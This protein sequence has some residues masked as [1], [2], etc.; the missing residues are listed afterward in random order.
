MNDT[1]KMAPIAKKNIQKPP[2]EYLFDWRGIDAYGKQIDGDIRAP[3]QAFAKAQLARQGIRTKRVQK[4]KVE[5]HNSRIKPKDISVF[6]RQLATMMKAGLPLLQAFDIVARGS[7]NPALSLLIRNIRS[8]V[9]TGTAMSAA[10]RKFPEYFSSLYCNLI[11]AG[12]AAGILDAMLDRLAVYLEKTEALKSKIKSALMY[13]SAVVLISITVLTIIMVFVVPSFKKIFASFGQELPAPTLVVIALS[14]AFVDNWYFI[15]G[16]ILIGGFVFLRL[17][18]TDTALQIW[19]DRSKLR[20]PIVGPLIEKACV[21]RW[22]RTLSTM[23]AAGV[24]LVEA[25]TSVGAAAGNLVFER[26]T[27]RIRQE[28]SIGTSLGAA[29]TRSKLFPELVLQMASIGEESGALDRMLAK[30][31]DFYEAEID[32]AVAGLS[33]LI[34]P[35]IIVVLGGVIGSIVVAMYLP[36]F[37]MGNVV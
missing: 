11:A 26:G 31:A 8:D 30:V 15:L 14:D 21:A 2:K 1:V 36:I 5:R 9:E 34:E 24:P 33:S 23:F 13:P 6:T 35:I 28:V 18:R 32:D 19:V 16:G 3:S 17:L 12:E 37:K 25:L 27:E 29:M 10:F 4:R 7:G 22:A 20:L